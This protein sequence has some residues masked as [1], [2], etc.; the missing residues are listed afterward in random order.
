MCLS[1]VRLWVNPA[2][3]NMRRFGLRTGME[4]NDFVREFET[5]SATSRIHDWEF[6][7][8]LGFGLLRI[9]SCAQ[10]PS[11]IDCLVGDFLVVCKLKSGRLGGRCVWKINGVFWRVGATPPPPPHLPDDAVWDGSSRSQGA[12]RGASPVCERYVATV[13]PSMDAKRDTSSVKRILLR[14]SRF[15][16]EM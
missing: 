16:E 5:P 9:P 11:L 10:T 2:H 1:W 13:T 4:S 8:S 7:N 15:L 6:S 14:L 12:S 3:E